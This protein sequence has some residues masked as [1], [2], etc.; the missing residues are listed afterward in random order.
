MNKITRK[1]TDSEG[2]SLYISLL[3]K[4]NEFGPKAVIGVARSGL[5]YATWIA[6]D[7]DLP[8]AVY[9]PKKTKLVFENKL[10]QHVVFVDDNILKG[11]TYTD[12]KWFMQ[13]Y[14]P[15][16]KWQWSVLF[17]DWSTPEVIRNEIIEGGQLDYFA[18]EPIWGSRKISLDQGIRYRDK[19]YQNN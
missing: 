8:L 5:P 7:L 9:W 18:Q 2:L 10:P 6:Q 4:I 15:D 14:Y 16:H 13:T 12:A 11:T 19:F 3:T 17:S 1:M